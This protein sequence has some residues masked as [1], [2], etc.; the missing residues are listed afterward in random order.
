M[1]GDWSMVHD[2]WSMVHGDSF[3]ALGGGSMRSNGISFRTY[4]RMA[5]HCFG[6]AE[7]LQQ[8]DRGS[9]GL[10]SPRLDSGG[11]LLPKGGNNKRGGLSWA[12]WLNLGVERHPWA[13]VIPA[14]GWRER[15]HPAHQRVLA[16][17]CSWMLMLA[18]ASI[19]HYERHA[20]V[21]PEYPGLLSCPAAASVEEPNW[22]ACQHCDI[23]SAFED[24]TETCLEASACEE[25]FS[26][27]GCSARGTCP[28]AVVEALAAA[29]H[30]QA[31]AWAAVVL[32]VIPC[33]VRDMPSALGGGTLPAPCYRG[34]DQ[35]GTALQPYVRS[36]ALRAV[37]TVQ[38]VREGA[39]SAGTW[40]RFWWRTEVQRQ[41]A[42]AVFQQLE[43]AEGRKHLFVLSHMRHMNP[44]DIRR[45]WGKHPGLRAIVKHLVYSMFRQQLR[46]ERD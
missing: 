46:S 17:M 3:M 7:C 32:T 42:W 11:E 22:Q 16:L 34:Y 8:Q 33:L 24:M 19:A 37:Q 1:D 20:S 15:D 14:A 35:L 44:E 40:A 21:C 4:E 18:G 26:R 10:A 27:R 36:A 41:S 25:H 23:H 45:A 39:I 38:R 6:A 12:A 29:R 30:W 43:A 13:S 31:A 9:P 28:E 5:L 2:G